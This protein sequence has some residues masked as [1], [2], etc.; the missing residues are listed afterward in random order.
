ME[1]RRAIKPAEDPDLFLVDPHQ[2]ILLYCNTF[3]SPLS[4][5]YSLRNLSEISE[6][7]LSC[8][9]KDSEKENVLDPSLYLDPQIIRR[10]PARVNEVSS[11]QKPTPN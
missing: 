2:I 10:N 1:S 7:C 9:V 3:N 8:S 5:N 11:G 6:N 4:T